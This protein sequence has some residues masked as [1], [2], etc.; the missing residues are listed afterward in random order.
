MHFRWDSEVA[1]QLGDELIRLEEELNSCATELENGTA[2]LREMQGSGTGD[3][4]ER[5]IRLGAR[6]KKA[7]KA[8]E[9][10]FAGTG[11]GIRRANEMFEE[12]ERRLRRRC[13]GMD[14]EA[15]GTTPGVGVP[16]VSNDHPAAGA[17]DEGR[18][19]EPEPEIPWSL[20]PGIE[21]TVAIDMHVP[22][23]SM[24]VPPWLQEIING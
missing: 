22:G 13:D 1:Q 12:N 24:V 16:L 8:L 15:P 11:R 23:K 6:L 20:L 10:D 18:F 9:E 5:Y 19:C 7:L 4:I 21:Q 2:I 17:D 14:G 3:A